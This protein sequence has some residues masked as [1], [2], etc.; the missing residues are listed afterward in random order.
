M[1]EAKEP[2]LTAEQIIAERLRT[3]Q[4]KLIEKSIRSLWRSRSELY[5]CGI[6]RTSET[7]ARN[8]YLKTAF[9]K[10]QGTMPCLFGAEVT[11]DTFLDR[12]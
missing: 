1:I 5:P 12:R 10:G 11:G 9:V 2:E 4:I 8:W 7:T 6:L 3:E